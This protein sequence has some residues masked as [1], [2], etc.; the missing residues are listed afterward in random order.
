MISHIGLGSN[1]GD[2]VEH[3]RRAIALLAQVAVV[4]ALSSLYETE[5][6]GLRE[7][8]PFLNAACC[9]RTTLAPTDLLHE[10][11][12]IEAALG[13]ERIERWGPRTVDLDMLLY[14]GL[15]L[16]TPELTLPHPL[17]AERAF[18][19]VPLAEIA[20]N[21]VHPRLGQTIAELLAIVPGREGV[22][23]WGTL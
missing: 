1:L 9:V 14:D 20:P 12:R 23:R 8:P 22:R 13:R 21:L 5:P 4:D 11:Q 18:V 17:L 3:I 16:D 2:R 19:L 7:Q 15:V 6:W 10:L